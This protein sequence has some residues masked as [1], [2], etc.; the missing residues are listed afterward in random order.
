MPSGPKTL[1]VEKRPDG[2]IL[3]QSEIALVEYERS[4]CDNLEKWSREAPDRIWLAQRNSTNGW[5]TLNYAEAWARTQA[6]GQSLLDLGLSKE[7][8]VAILSGNSIE[9]ALVMMASMAIGLAVAPISPSYSQLPA[10][11]ERLVKIAQELRPDAIFV[12]RFA[13][14]AHV[15]DIPEFATAKWI[16]ADV[17]DETLSLAKLEDNK[18]GRPFDEAFRAVEPDMVAKILFTSGSTGSPKGAVNTHRMLTSSVA[19]ARS[20]F[21]GPPTA[22]YPVQVE[23]LPWHHT[24]GGNAIFNQIL[25]AG[26]S[27]YIDPG[28]P[29]PDAFHQTIAALRQVSPTSMINVP[30]GLTLLVEA[31]ENDADLRTS[32]FKRLERISTG[33]AAVQAELLE[34]FQKLAVE[35]VGMRIPFFSAYGTTETALNISMTYWPTE[36]AAELGLPMPGLHL[37]LVP[38][39][40]RYELRVKGPSV[41]PGYIG[42]PDRNSAVFDE[43]GFY[44]TGDAATFV[45]PLDLSR[46]LR[47]AGRLNE[48]FKLSSGTWVMTGDI[49]LAVLKAVKPLLQDVVIAG[50]NRDEVTILGWVNK[51]AAKLHVRDPGAL[52]DP[53][54]LATDEGILSRIKWALDRYNQDARSS[55]RISAFRL[56][57]APPSIEAGEVTDK[58][59]INQRRVLKNRAH[60][61]EELYR[62]P[63]AHGVVRL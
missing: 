57:S 15:R 4:M 28:R 41:T 54:R 12:Q 53:A 63:P 8:R 31:M 7:G 51:D 38:S 47:F 1:K 45:D 25:K 43:D 37:K 21:P 9:H 22:D 33:G 32:V 30:A 39:A 16:S 27:L 35:T 60:L 46:G 18:P 3:L 23:W 48:N 20:I 58:A 59:S 52:Q 29:T 13:S 44:C 34:R 61:V 49:R 36:E 42:A 56:L 62:E 2:T 10:A 40:D 17:H 5:E 19:M 50:E 24:T 6:I 14:F 11:R 26:G 55:T